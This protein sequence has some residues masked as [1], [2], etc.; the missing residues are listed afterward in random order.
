MLKARLDRES[1]ERIAL[2]KPKLTSRRMQTVEPRKNVET[3]VTNIEI[4]KPKPK[5]P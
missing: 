3:H 4:W 1:N 2:L 5:K